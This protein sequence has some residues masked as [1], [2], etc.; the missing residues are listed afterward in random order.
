M[1]GN[2][3]K[4]EMALME[5]IMSIAHEILTVVTNHCAQMCG[6]YCLH[7]HG[8]KLSCRLMQSLRRICNFLG[9]KLRNLIESWGLFG[10]LDLTMNWALDLELDC[11]KWF[12]DHIE[13]E[14]TLM[15]SIM[16]IVHEIVTVA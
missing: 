12:G 5:S 14:M 8:L 3:I 1:L 6:R 4:S 7:S 9:N 16:S 13:S 15:E 11:D 2:R 10:S